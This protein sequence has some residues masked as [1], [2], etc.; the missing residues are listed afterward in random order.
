MRAGTE[1]GFSRSWLRR[2]GRAA[3]AKAVRPLT[4]GKG[5]SDM[6]TSAALGFFDGVHLG[7]RR[8][9]ETAVQLAG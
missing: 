8:V 9:I 2:K 4:K 6:K 3:D 5:G 7:H 1:R